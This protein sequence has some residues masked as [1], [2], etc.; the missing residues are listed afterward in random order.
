VIRGIRI[1]VTPATLTLGVGTVGVLT[2][3]IVYRSDG[4]AVADIPLSWSVSDPTKALLVWPYPEAHQA[5]VS[6][7]AEG[8]PVTITA[9]TPTQS[10]TATVNVFDWAGTWTGSATSLHECHWLDPLWDI[11]VVDF[12]RLDTSPGDMPEVSLSVSNGSDGTVSGTF[13][14]NLSAPR[15][16]FDFTAPVTAAGISWSA[17]GNPLYVDDFWNPGQ[18]PPFDFTE[19]VSMK[20]TRV[21]VSVIEGEVS[22][23]GYSSYSSKSAAYDVWTFTQKF[24]V[25]R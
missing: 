9:T 18:G 19:S 11:G 17:S 24:T 20:L 15:Q 25:S 16:F 14:H 22:L 3:D 6:G 1:T 2:A 23:S 10:A 12:C 8:G 5:Q 7:V 13:H 21:S 4:S